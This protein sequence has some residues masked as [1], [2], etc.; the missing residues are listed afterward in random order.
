MRPNSDQS[1]ASQKAREYERTRVKQS[2]SFPY[3]STAR[4]PGRLTSNRILYLSPDRPIYWN[5]RLGTRKAPSGGAVCSCKKR[6]SPLMSLTNLPRALA[7]CSS[8]TTA[9]TEITFYM[10]LSPHGTQHRH[11]ST[12]AYTSHCQVEKRRMSATPTTKVRGKLTSGLWALQS[13]HAY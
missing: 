8:Y 9:P 1:R 6:H 7:Q 11:D 3:P 5:E 4:A 12:G 13:V 2:T 10:P